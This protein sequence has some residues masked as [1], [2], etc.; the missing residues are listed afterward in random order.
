MNTTVTPDPRM[1]R[2][3][4]RS[5]LVGAGALVLCAL[6]YFLNS[7][8]F[9]RSYLLGYLFWVGI[10]LG[11]FALIMLH[12]LAGGGWGFTIQRILESSMRT[13]PVL[14]LLAVPLLFGLSDLYLWARPDVV[15]AD[16][17]LL[18]K[19]AY[20]NVPFFVIRTVVYFLIW[21]ALGY[22]L[23][24]W[25]LEQD[26]SGDPSARKRME[27]L[28]GPGLILMGLTITFSSVDWVMSLEPHWF[29]TMYGFLF[30]V[31]DVLATLA[32]SIC[33]VSIVA[34]RA[35]LSR[36]A[37]AG[38]FH[39]L[40]NLLLAFVMLWAYISFSQFL[41][42]WSGNLKEEIPWYLHRTG[43]G[44]IVIA[45]AL[46]VLHFALPFILLLSR[47]TKRGV[48]TLV[49]V[50]AFL[51]LMRWVD[52]Y[53]LVA[54]NF[55]QHEL[56]LHWMDLAAPVGIGG[57]WLAVFLGLWSKVPLLPMNDPRLVKLIEETGGHE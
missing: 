13:I 21:A 5:L 20:L 42:I 49:S 52:L 10:A 27:G 34:R 22:F 54:P 38:R 48:S 57:I 16:E 37:D 40:G 9:F 7:E 32:F 14:A 8:Q 28:S 2:L 33:M 41:I 35:P 25:S 3:E 4:R 53:W 6:G 1:A 24:R 18:H 56:Y 31:G 26:R 11:S 19:S 50:A 39:D 44:W 51:L 15:A 43:P 23:S 36:I 17:V 46:I 12:H 47:R 45:L 55:H 29:S 30:M